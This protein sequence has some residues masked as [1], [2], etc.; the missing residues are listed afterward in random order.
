ME[1]I[2]NKDSLIDSKKIT[3]QLIKDIKKQVKIH[4]QR[5]TGKRLIKSD[6]GKNSIS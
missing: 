4:T 3:E 2:K 5:S 1:I 6:S